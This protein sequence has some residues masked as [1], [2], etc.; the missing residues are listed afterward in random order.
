MTAFTAIL[1]LI[2]A[3]AVIAYF[4]ITRKPVTPAFAASSNEH[5]HDEQHLAILSALNEIDC[6]TL[7]SA[8]F[9][10]IV[11]L[12]FK[13]LPNFIPCTLV[14]VGQLDKDATEPPMLLAATV[15]GKRHSL[16]HILNKTLRNLINA[17]P[18]GSV[19]EPPEAKATLE[20]LADLGAAR[21]LLLP[22]YR[23]AELVAVLYVGYAENVQITEHSRRVSRYFSD[24][25]GVTLTLVTR[26]KSLYHTENFD[27]VTG[28]PNHRFCRE[29]LAFEILRAQRYQ[30]KI[31]VFYV[32]LEG[33]KKVNDA[34]GYA[35]SNAILNQSGQ[36]LRASIRQTDMISRFA[37]DEFVVVLANVN[38]TSGISKVATKLLETLS[39]HFMHEEHDYYLSPSIGISL[40]PDD[41]QLADVLI[42]KADTAMSL[43]KAKGRGQFMFHEAQMN[44]QA[45]LRL[46]IE[47]DLRQ[48][49]Q[50]NELFLQYQPQIDLRNGQIVGVEALVRWQHPSKGL[51]PPAE[52]IFIAEESNLMLQVGAQ[53]RKIACMQYREWLDKGMAPSKIAL[54][55]SSKEL[56][57][58]SFTKDFLALL[59]ET[60]IRPNC[61][62]LEITESLLLDIPG[63]VSTSL[64]QLRAEGVQIAIDDFGTGYSSLS[65]LAKL[66]FDV[67]KVDRAFVGKVGK[68]AERYEIVSVIINLAHHLQKTV[69]AEGV[70]NETQLNFLKDCGCESAQ[71]YFLSASLSAQDYEKFHIENNSKENRAKENRAKTL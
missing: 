9:E 13:H 29:Q 43:V 12:L 23:D 6:A 18:N 7:S 63:H 15:D 35:A 19:L 52:F 11:D 34:V 31:A 24:R 59:V 26:A 3:A 69:C 53:V 70:E 27:D 65:Y 42:Q 2:V 55:I 46:A 64:Q 17:D 37:N 58:E 57:L 25:L 21:I 71:G 14:A 56:M 50:K 66:P 61:V 33:L 4:F 49:V 47:R 8:S 28:L 5:E 41:G 45:I 32:N 54:N 40:F 16:N 30:Y 22:I 38:G 20:M 60:G 39:Q 44:K 10:L 48:A 67:L 1:L 51:I 36:R 62:E 68:S